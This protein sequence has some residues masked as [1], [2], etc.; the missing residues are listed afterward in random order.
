[1]GRNHMVITT[2][3]LLN[4]NCLRTAAECGDSQGF[5]SGSMKARGRQGILS[6]TRMTSGRGP[7]LKWVVFGVEPGHQRL[8]VSP[9]GRVLPILSVSTDEGLQ[10]EDICYLSRLLREVSLGT[11]EIRNSKETG[12]SKTLRGYIS[13]GLI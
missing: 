5:S 12:C 10:N 11:N 3:L 4:K 8:T 9:E 1:M 13:Q 2:E 7:G 6:E